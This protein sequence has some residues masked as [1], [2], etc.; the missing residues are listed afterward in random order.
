MNRVMKNGKRGLYVQESQNSAET[1][2][3]FLRA[4]YSKLAYWQLRRAWFL[5]QF[6]TL[7]L[8]AAVVVTCGSYLGHPFMNRQ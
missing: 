8:V 5:L 3:A 4:G 6:I 1:M 7:G 2:A